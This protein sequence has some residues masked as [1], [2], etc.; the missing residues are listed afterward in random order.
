MRMGLF[1][2]GKVECP[3]DPDS[4]EWI[5]ANMKWFAEE[6]GD[7]RLKAPV[8]LPVDEFFPFGLDGTEVQAHRMFAHIC[9]FME[10]NPDDVHLE[11]AE[12]DEPLTT[13][14]L[15]YNWSSDAPAGTYED[16]V[17]TKITISRAH[18]GNALGFVATAA[19]ELGHF[20]LLGQD[21]LDADEPDN[22][23]LTDLLTVYFG[24]GIFG[25]NAS[26]VERQYEGAI[27][28]AGWGYSRTGYLDFPMWGYSH[29]VF[30][31]ARGEDKPP[32]AAYLRPDVRALF[33]RGM[34][35]IQQGG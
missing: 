31:H 3:V 27:G 11:F 19:H 13:G 17:Y 20:L 34:K 30:A 29:A 2:F 35:Y 4:R 15:E 8:I 25:A 7:S 16:N 6:F 9:G 21:R 5:E 22:E 33:K 12:H 18:L 14:T 32:W 28:M 24:L 1:G 23:P 10:V 26:L